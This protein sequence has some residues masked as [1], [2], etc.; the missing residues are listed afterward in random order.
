L[1]YENKNKNKNK[2]KTIRKIKIKAF[3]N[4]NPP[5]KKIAFGGHGKQLKGL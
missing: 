2:N 4:R 1:N 3:I 5:Q